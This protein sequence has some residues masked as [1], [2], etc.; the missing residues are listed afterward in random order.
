[1]FWNKEKT[2]NFA[3][4][5]VKTKKAREK[6]RKEIEEHQKQITP[7]ALEKKA[8]EIHRWIASHAASRVILKN[9]TI[10][11]FDENQNAAKISVRISQI[12]EHLQ[13][14]IEVAGTGSSK[15]KVLKK[16]SFLSAKKN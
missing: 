8:T 15:E 13:K 6:L 9:K 10:S 16:W 5:S 1:M 2:K 7:I 11:L 12:A 3:E 14:E 4:E